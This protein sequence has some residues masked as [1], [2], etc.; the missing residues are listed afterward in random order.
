MMCRHTN[1]DEGIVVGGEPD[2]LGLSSGGG[3][4][5]GDGRDAD[6]V[7]RVC[8]GKYVS[9]A[10][11]CDGRADSNRGRSS[12]SVDCDGGRLE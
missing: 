12:M 8:C 7:E 1:F 10:I 6:G 11:G 3:I 9:L 2:L 5:H 4:G